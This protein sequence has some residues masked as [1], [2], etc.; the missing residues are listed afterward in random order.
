MKSGPDSSQKNF[1]ALLKTF[2]AV[3]CLLVL[4]G[5]S[6]G[7]EQVEADQAEVETEVEQLK[8][9]NEELRTELDKAVA[10]LK[11]AESKFRELENTLEAIQEAQAADPEDEAPE[12]EAPETALAMTNITPP[13]LSPKRAL[14]GQ[15]YLQTF[16][17]EGV[18]SC[19][20]AL[21]FREDGTGTISQTYYIPEDEVENYVLDLD[22]NGTYKYLLYDADMS[23][24]FSWSLDGEELHVDVKDKLNLNLIYVSAQ[25]LA[26]TSGEIAYGRGRPTG[27]EGYVERALYTEDREAKEA[28]RRRRF[29]GIWYYDVLTWTFNEDGT[30]VW[31]IPEL[32]DQPAEKRKFTYSV[33][34]N[35]G[36]GDYLCL[37]IDWED[38][39]YWTLFPT[40]NADGS[41]SLMG[42][43]QSEP[44]MKW[45]KTFDIDN[46][47]VT[48]Q[49]I[50][51]GLGVLSGSIFDDF[52]G[53]N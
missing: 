4:A 23:D 25:E 2:C 18:W 45:T 10:D 31:D 34:D 13:D 49:I 17:E 36:I 46:C 14:L 32:G 40:F 47:P 7:N 16:H 5:C 35:S 28:A 39:S 33:D 15:W 26:L 21:L 20:Q 50:S 8:N 1:F 29:L 44:V 22:G 24:E 27:M 37:T 9:E 11:A 41:M 48:E 19:T 3:L 12:T 30:G 42:I 6:G 52:L 51:N 38:S 43:G 53:G